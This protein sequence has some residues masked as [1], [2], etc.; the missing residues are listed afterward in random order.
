MK[1][2]FEMNVE[3][4]N[5]I[6]GKLSD[7]LNAMILV[8][9]TEEGCESCEDCGSIYARYFDESCKGWTKDPD[10]NKMFLCH[11]Q[12]YCNDKLRAKGY[13]FLNEVYDQ[14]GIPRTK[15]GAVVGWVYDEENPIGDN[16]VDFCIHSFDAN[17]DFVNG[18]NNV[19]LLDFNVDGNILDLI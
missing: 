12:N 16:K 5:E 2:T 19:V 1:I 8:E 3:E 14:L 9:E 4:F 15:A 6:G 17:R 18:Y 7:I 13:L 11:Q 10:Y